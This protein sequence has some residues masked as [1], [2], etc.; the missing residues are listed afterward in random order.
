MKSASKEKYHIVLFK[1]QDHKKWR[2]NNDPKMTGLDQSLITEKKLL[3]IDR[4]TG[5]ALFRKLK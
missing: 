5:T 4:V 1:I 2:I 3:E